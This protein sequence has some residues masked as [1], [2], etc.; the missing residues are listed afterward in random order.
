MI[1][2]IDSVNVFPWNDNLETGIEIIDQQHQK[3]VALLNE[4]AHSL[5]KTD[6][7]QMQI[8][9]DELVEYAAY[10]FETEEKIWHEI[11]GN[12]PWYRNHQASHQAFLPELEGLGRLN[13][14]SDDKQV[15]EKMV[16]FLIKWLAFHIIGDDKKMSLVLDGKRQGLSLSEAKF[17]SEQE[18]ANAI[19]VL[20]DT[21]LNM[22]D[23][24]SGQ[25][26]RLM[27]ETELRLEAQ[28]E[29]EKANLRLRAANQKLEQLA[30]TDQLTGVYNRRHMEMQLAQEIKRCRRE[31]EFLSVMMLDLDCFKQLNDRYG[32][33][34]GDKA[35]KMV[36]KHLEEI[37]NRPSD[38]VCRIGGE[39]FCIVT[40]GM[41]LIKTQYFAQAIC[42][43]VRRLA[44]AN[45]NSTADDVLTVSI[46][47]YCSIP[48][49]QDSIH[50]MLTH[51]DKG[52]Y[53]AK[54]LGRNQVA[55]T[56]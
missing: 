44:I 54:S 30:I 6:H 49:M 28:Q 13:H 39:E 21:V 55:I 7:E 56:T 51:A 40:T 15:A 33:P 47:I 53:L 3:L 42:D 23:E 29:L 37:C 10:H 34:E 9:F 41:D 14:N 52:L 43:K 5:V 17:H 2:H 22:Y 25:A 20:A 11:F 12:D 48:N 19:N 8:V 4:L 50:S 26:I 32:H 18:M 45:V 35:L 24:L 1:K 38:L 27:R 16:K 46:G 36:A 31:G